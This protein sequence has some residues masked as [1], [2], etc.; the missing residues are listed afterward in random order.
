M[1]ISEY[2]D[3]IKT[4]IYIILLTMVNFYLPIFSLAVMIL[5]PV[6][7]VYLVQKEKTGR[8]ITVIAIAALINGALFGPLMGL[9][10]VIGFG[11][12]GFIIGNA[13]KEGLSPKKTL[14]VSVVAVIISQT[15]IML[16]ADQILGINL[17]SFIQN[18][19]KS[20]SSDLDQVSLEQMVNAQIGFISMILPALLAVSS[21]ITG[22]FNYYI[23]AWYLRR[24]GLNIE[25]YKKFNKWFMPRWPISA[26]VVVSL[27]LKNNP[28]FFNLNI[29]L[30]F[31]A[32]LQGFAVLMYFI[33]AKTDSFLPKILAVFII[34]ILP[35]I[36][37]ALIL[38]GFIDMWF[39]LRKQND[40][41]G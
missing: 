28:I 2:K 31:L 17:Q 18:A 8:V 35:P 40:Q 41:P 34:L 24:R 21:T 4:I 3:S 10:T 39:N 6:P 29:Y 22:I 19:V 9:M 11:L 23:S 32:F 27:F 36:P 14:I 16:I 30:F 25:I 37:M 13:V 26:A 20:F 15:L 1:N 5:W 12:V 38:L 33:S 7:V